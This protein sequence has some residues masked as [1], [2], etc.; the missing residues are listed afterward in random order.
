MPNA[1]K[2][3]ADNLEWLE[4]KWDTAWEEQESGELK[5]VSEWFFDDVTERQLD[6][7]ERIGLEFAKGHPTKGQASDIIGLFEPVEEEDIEILK[8]FKIS[9][10]G[11]NQS[12]AS[13]IVAT[14]FLDSD[15][16]DAW[17]GRPASTMQKEFY[18][19]FN[20]KIPKGLTYEDASSFITEYRNKLQDED[21]KIMNDWDAYEDIY[22][23]INEPYNREDY[24]IKK[25]SLSIYRDAI[26]ELRI[27]GK[28]PSD[29]E[30][31][32]EIIVDKIIQ[33][34]PDIRKAS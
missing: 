17:Q 8:F 27:E 25:V 4:E 6:R 29:L 23:E 26:E 11:M 10:R 30:D 31:N 24:L 20:L 7:I 21:E 18:K 32:P 22:L 28:R 16:I 34:R 9:T 13:H 33:I 15:N 5:T 19:Y 2:I 12:K 1:E 3:L 14:I